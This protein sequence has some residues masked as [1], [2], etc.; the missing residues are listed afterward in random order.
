ML[1]LFSFILAFK[2]RKPVCLEILCP[3]GILTGGLIN[4]FYFP[5]LSLVTIVLSRDNWSG[6]KS[7]PPVQFLP[8]KYGPPWRKV[9]RAYKSL[10]R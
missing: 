9:I 8:A 3:S 5:F 6:V 10:Q 1:R 2:N 7:G 4:N